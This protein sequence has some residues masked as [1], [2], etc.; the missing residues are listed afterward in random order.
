MGVLSDE[1]GAGGGKGATTGTGDLDGEA[2][3]D[4]LLVQPPG[5]TVLARL[6]VARVNGETGQG[7]DVGRA[8]HRPPPAIARNSVVTTAGTRACCSG[9]NP[10]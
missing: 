1:Q 5:S 3:K 9:D 8:H 4:R 10:S 7:R 2:L 6:L